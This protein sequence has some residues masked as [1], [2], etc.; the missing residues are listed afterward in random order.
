MLKTIMAAAAVSTLALTTALAQTTTPPAGSTPST[1]TPLAA[2]STPATPA[3]SASNTSA[4]G[5]AQFVT[6]QTQEQWL[7][8]KFKG[9]D[10]IGTDDK[11]IGD[12]SDILFD[13]DKK[14]IAYIVGVGGFLGIG[15]K[16]VAI[17]PDSFQMVPASA[18]RSGSG[19]SGGTTTG[20][21][22]GSTASSSN[23]HDNFKLRL[24]MTKDELK[25]APAFEQYNSRP[26]TTSQ[27][28]ANRPAGAPGTT[29]KQ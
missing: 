6:K 16:D 9:T 29:P 23:D 14:I 24:S 21:N 19:T 1:T 11:K 20:T 15:Q 5:K 22:T 10:V 26:A 3:P 18:S 28:P 2:T 12:V 13:K 17:A 27:A 25:A 8:T 7:A 4:A